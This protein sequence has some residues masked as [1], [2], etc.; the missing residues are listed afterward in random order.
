MGVSDGLTRTENR[1]GP[2]KKL[3]F[4]MTER[5]VGAPKRSGLWRVYV[6]AFSRGVRLKAKGS[7]PEIAP[8]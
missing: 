3:G 6:D 7:F 8:P 2:K 4:L 5:M 1:L